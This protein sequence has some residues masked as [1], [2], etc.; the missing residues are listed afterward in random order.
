MTNL[1]TR[2]NDTSRNLP[3]GWGKSLRSGLEAEERIRHYLT[4]IGVEWQPSS[5]REDTRWDIDLWV[6]GRAWS[7]KRQDAGLRYGHVYF[8]LEAQRTC[9]GVWV[10]SWYHNSRAAV[11]AIV[12]GDTLRCYESI[13]IRDY[14][15]LNGW[16]R[17]RTLS[18]K[19]RR[20]Q[21]GN[22]VFQDAR[23]GFIPFDAVRHSAHQL[24]GGSRCA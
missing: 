9:D 16:E 10:P 8:E 22:Y 3:E 5:R 13:D 4:A 11:Y 24:P 21:G 19:T 7:I 20:Y 1:E 23:C 14:V 6:D 17:T 12:Q 2:L 18:A 15:D